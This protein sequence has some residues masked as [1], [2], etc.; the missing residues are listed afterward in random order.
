MELNQLIE[1]LLQHNINAKEHPDEK[2]MLISEHLLG[3]HNVTIISHIPSDFPFTLPTFHLHER[4]K[5][6]ALAHVAWG[7][8]G[9]AD[10]C[11]GADSYNIDYSRP[12]FIFL[13]ALSKMLTLLDKSLNDQDFNK[14]ELLR[15][16]AGVW[17]FHISDNTQT[18]VCLAEPTERFDNLMVRAPN[19]K[20]IKNNREIL[21]INSSLNQCNSNNFFMKKLNSKTRSSEGKG[22][23]LSLPELP[24]PPEPNESIISWWENVISNLPVDLQNDL[25]EKGRLTRTKN[26][27]IICHA[28]NEE[29]QVWF[30]LQCSNIKK[31][32]IPIHARYFCNWNMNA[33]TLDVVSKENLLSRIGVENQLSDKKVCLIGCGSVG[34]YIA[35]MLSSSGVGEITLVDPDKFQLE[36]LHRHYLGAHTI[37]NFKTDALKLTLEYKYPFIKINTSKSRLLDYCNF[38]KLTRFDL[39]ICATGNVT[40]QRRIN[41]F[42]VQNKIPTPLIFC[43]VE[44]YGVG[45]HA[46]AV[47]PNSQGCLNNVFID[48]ES[49]EPSLYPNINF[50]RKDQ[51]IKKNHAGCGTE[52]IAYSNIDAIQTATISSQLALKVLSNNLENSGYI[53]WRGEQ[54]L[55]I[56]NEIKLAH[57]FYRFKDLMHFIPLACEKM[58]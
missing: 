53:S 14:K 42:I 38:E 23:I 34:G 54:D 36:N 46:V 31:E 13:S 40:H 5:Y 33:V 51:K 50:I 10:I 27:Y 20:K 55:A 16:F 26:F 52:F 41:E 1:F 44:A 2:G 57:R 17:R 3:N 15:E 22:I 49:D 21:V 45:G 9:F 43:W 4:E 30:A 28:K 6:G 47:L 29:G 12:K 48:N 8:D 18:L 24:L 37:G 58:S 25:L 56:K 32:N 11:Y 7:K 19:N 39:V 35:D